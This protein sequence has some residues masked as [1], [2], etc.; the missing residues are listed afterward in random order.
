MYFF[1]DC[2][3]NSKNSFVNILISL[4]NKSDI[5]WSLKSL[6]ANQSTS[7]YQVT[8]LS[9]YQKNQLLDQ[10]IKLSI[11]EVSNNIVAIKK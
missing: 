1:R 10:N 7:K 9:N 4:K 11:Q 3:S 8:H 2:L 5:K 6:N